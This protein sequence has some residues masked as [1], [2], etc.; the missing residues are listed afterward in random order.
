MSFNQHE[1]VVW[2][3]F[4]HYSTSLDIVNCLRIDSYL[5]PSQSESFL[6]IS[7]TEAE[8]RDLFS[9]SKAKR[10]ETQELPVALFHAV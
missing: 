1:A 5:K 3:M 8:Q 6:R 7:V 2:N 9:G 4:V 10:Y